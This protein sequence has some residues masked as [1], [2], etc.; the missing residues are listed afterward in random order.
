MKLFLFY[1]EKDKKSLIE[2][3][4]L[5]VKNPL[6]TDRCRHGSVNHKS[7]LAYDINLK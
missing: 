6:C 5:G 3:V 7:E 2:L 1:L 4:W